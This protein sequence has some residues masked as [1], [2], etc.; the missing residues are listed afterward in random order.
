MFAN[1]KSNAS[2]GDKQQTC[3]YAAL[4]SVNTLRAAVED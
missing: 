2:N 1:F 3:Y 4:P